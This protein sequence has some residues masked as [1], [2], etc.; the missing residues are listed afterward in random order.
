MGN[1]NAELDNEGHYVNGNGWG[2]VTIES[3]Q[4]TFEGK[5]VLKIR[6]YITIFGEF[7]CHGIG[8]SDGK[9][10]KGTFTVN[11]F[12]VPATLNAEVEILN[13]HGG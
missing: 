9:L 5:L 3:D 4:G 10:L 1:L 7:T 6:D 12:T 11:V 8:M 13:P 2:T